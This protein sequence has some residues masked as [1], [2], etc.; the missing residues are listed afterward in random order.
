MEQTLKKEERL[1]RGGFRNRRW[2]KISETEHFVLFKDKNSNGIKRIGI[3]VKKK[4]GRAVERNRIRRVLKEF[5][6]LNKNLFMENVDHLIRVKK[7]P[8]NLTW[9]EMKEE[10]KILLENIKSH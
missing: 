1:N 7:I 8:E 3:V 2:Y 10:L 4:V 5:Y 9:K 6:R